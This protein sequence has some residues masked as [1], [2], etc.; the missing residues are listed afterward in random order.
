MILIGNVT[1]DVW[2]VF[3][4]GR[5]YRVAMTYCGGS[6]VD[7][8]GHHLALGVWS[9]R[10]HENE[11]RFH[12]VQFGSERVE[13]RPP[14]L[15]IPISGTGRL[16][17]NIWLD[18]E[19]KRVKNDGKDDRLGPRYGSEKPDYDK[20]I[21]RH[22]RK[23]CWFCRRRIHRIHEEQNPYETNDRC[24]KCGVILEHWDVMQ[25]ER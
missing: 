6:I 18:S 2:V 7:H 20:W 14:T 5:W 22:L 19:N 16:S 21:R 8:E 13:N 17:G 24:P 9:K 25:E 23:H 4:S 15:V 3:P 11:H 10:L 12:T 1:Y